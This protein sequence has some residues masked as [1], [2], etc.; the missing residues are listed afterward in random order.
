MNDKKSFFNLIVDFF[1][2]QNLFQGLKYKT[3]SSGE[4]LIWSESNGVIYTLQ[5]RFQLSKIGMVPREISYWLKEE[6]IEKIV[7]PIAINNSLNYDSSFEHT[8]T[9]SVYEKDIYKKLTSGILDIT[10][11]KEQFEIYFSK[12]I[13]PFFESRNTVEGLGAYVLEHTFDNII[14]IGLGGEYPVN[15]LKAITIAKLCR[16]EAK[17]EEY[18]KGLQTWI[19]EDRNDSNYAEICESYQMALD[20]LKEKLEMEIS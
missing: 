19:D 7:E 6:S 1:N 12:E 15:V 2:N 17:Y 18:T 14:N 3:V 5:T 11:F 10:A 16:N 13:N 4:L 9:S 20:M 8:L